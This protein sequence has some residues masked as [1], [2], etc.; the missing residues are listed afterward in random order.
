MP[1]RYTARALESSVRSLVLLRS[2][3]T[4]LVERVGGLTRVSGAFNE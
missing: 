2:T 1:S 4:E 3:G